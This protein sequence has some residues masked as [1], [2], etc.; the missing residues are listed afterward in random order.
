MFTQTPPTQGSSH[1]LKP[2]THS[3][4]LFSGVSSHPP[5]PPLLNFRR[6]TP[7]KIFGAAR[8]QKVIISLSIL[9]PHFTYPVAPTLH[10]PTQDVAGSLLEKSVINIIFGMCVG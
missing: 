3:G 5:P 9:L 6:V 4:L 2:P 7:E 1:P 8:Q 10:P